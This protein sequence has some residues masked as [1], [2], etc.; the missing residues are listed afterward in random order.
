MLRMLSEFC[1]MYPTAARVILKRDN[2]PNE[3]QIIEGHPVTLFQ[4][5]LHEQLS[6]PVDIGKVRPGV[7]E[8]CSRFLQSVCMR[9]VEGRKRIVS[10]ITRIL[11]VI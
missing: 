7:A 3:N 8:E 2:K 5:L 1:M 6:L 4:F 11:Q 9:S 10:E